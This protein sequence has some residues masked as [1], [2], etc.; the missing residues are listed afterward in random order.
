MIIH[1]VDFEKVKDA[2]ASI[3]LMDRGFLYGD[4]IYEVV[5]TYDKKLFLPD[6]HFKRLKNSA[7]R[8]SLQVPFDLDRLRSHVKDLI[9]DVD[10]DCYIRL[11]VTRGKDSVFDLWPNPGLKPKTVVLVRKVHEYPQ[12]FYT[13]GINLAIVSVRRNPKTALDPEIKS[14]NYLNNVLAIME[15]KFKGANDAL[16][17]NEKGFV[18]ESTTSN[19]FIVKGGT[20][21]TPNL[22]SGI[23]HGITRQFLLDVMKAKN[24]EHDVKN[25]TPEDVYSADECF[26][27]ATTKEVMPVRIC[28]GKVVGRGEPGEVTKRLMKLYREEALKA[29]EE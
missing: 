14:G 8:L 17:I 1:S 29:V 4:S 19:V 11:I 2:D 7:K 23:L 10:Y 22:E 5:R 27:T 16:M 15:A 9:R 12:E 24:V 18:T 25:I 20:V 13:K 3:S 26:V 21:L 6:K 28:D